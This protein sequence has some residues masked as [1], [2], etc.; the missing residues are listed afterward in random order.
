[1]GTAFQYRLNEKTKPQHIL[2]A[3]RL[4]INSQK[5]TLN[6]R[7]GR[8][9]KRQHHKVPHRATQRPHRIRQLQRQVVHSGHEPD[10]WSYLINAQL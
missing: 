9:P 7:Q 3:H 4:V 6:N 1:M 2:G 8:T 10:C 5:V